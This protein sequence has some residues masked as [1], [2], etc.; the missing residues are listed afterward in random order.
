MNEQIWSLALKAGPQDQLEAAQYF[1]QADMPE[2]AVRLYHKAGMLH[3]AV[4][5]A[6][7]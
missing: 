1:E 6:F 5:L 3:K 7:Q 2:R 4:D